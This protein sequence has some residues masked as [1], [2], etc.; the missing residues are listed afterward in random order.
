MLEQPAQRNVGIDELAQP[1]DRL[2]RE[3]GVPPQVAKKVILH[4]DPLDP[5]AGGGV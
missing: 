1:R 4:A 2:G 3:E 5:G